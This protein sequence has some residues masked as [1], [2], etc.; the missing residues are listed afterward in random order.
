MWIFVCFGVPGWRYF[1][2]QVGYSHNQWAGV[3]TGHH[4][5]LGK[6]V[7][8]ITGETLDDTHD[9][10]YRQKLA[11]LLVENKGYLKKEIQSRFELVAAAGDSK[12]IVR[13]DYVITLGGKTGM[14]IKYGP[15]S[16]VTR[17]RSVLAASRLVVPYQI[18][19]A[20]VT[21]GED[22]DIL[23]GKKGNVLARGLA[24]IPAKSEL[25]AK[26]ESAAFSAIAAERAEKESRILYCY[27]VDDSC[28]CDDTICRL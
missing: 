28:P 4:L 25:K 20:V 21:N 24:A 22:A 10:R 5:I 8:F 2:R 23:D 9:E 1:E 6:L 11:H 3:M 17:H 7:D 27:E 12:A 26:I 16:L 19:I 13:V 15:G 18:P 14:I